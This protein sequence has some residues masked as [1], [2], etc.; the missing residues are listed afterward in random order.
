M[1]LGLTDDQRALAE[2]LRDW[3]RDRGTTDVVK[4][5]EG[6]GPE[7][8]ADTWA[9]LAGLGVAAIAVPESLGGA[10]GF[11]GRPRLRARGLRRGDGARAAAV[12]RGGRDGPRRARR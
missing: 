10:G 1:A 5:A 2:S 3:A 9:A 12:H 11:A 8:F 4:A 6:Q 7:A